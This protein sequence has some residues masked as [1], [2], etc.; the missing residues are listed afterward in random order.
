MPLGAQQRDGQARNGHTQKGHDRSGAARTGAR[1][2]AGRAV[3]AGRAAARLARQVEVG[4]A[5]VGLSLSQYRVLA[6]LGE[7]CAGASFLASKLAVSKPSLTAVVDGLVARGLI[8][9]EHEK[10][11]RR[12]VSHILTG[13]GRDLLVAADASI[14]AR[15]SAITGHLPPPAASD[16]LDGLLLWNDALDLWREARVAA[17][18]GVGAR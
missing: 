15:L 4:L 16:A 14:E 9:R 11:D 6:F 10:A 3:A 12:R 17:A 5:A 2:A 8:E 7:G 18:S 1:E 13:A